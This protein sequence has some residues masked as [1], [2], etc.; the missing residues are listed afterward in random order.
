LLVSQAKDYVADV[1][2]A[3]PPAPVQRLVERISSAMCHFF[4]NLSDEKINALVALDWIET[5]REFPFDCVLKAFADW[6]N[7]SA[8]K[9]TPS[10]IRALAITAYGRREWD[11]L[12]RAKMIA[13]MMPSSTA[14]EK[15]DEPWI[16]PT[17]EQKANVARMCEEARRNLAGS[18][19]LTK[20]ERMPHDRA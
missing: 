13:G 18:T 5:L 9:P 11:Y 15:V 17:P 20:P 8:K 4:A 14:I 19:P 2:K 12:Q 10:E 6:R 7:S 1:A 16:P 3:R